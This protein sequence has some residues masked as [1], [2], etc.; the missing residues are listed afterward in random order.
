MGAVCGNREWGGE[1]QWGHLHPYLTVGPT[2]RP[3]CAG[4][5][6]WRCRAS[7]GHRLRPA[8][9]HR[10]FGV[11]SSSDGVG[12][13]VGS[14]TRGWAGAGLWAAAF[15][16]CCSWYK[17]REVGAIVIPILEMRTLRQGS[18]EEAVPLQFEA[19]VV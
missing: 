10:P 7:H 8:A 11:C 2:P 5:R 17:L 6:G 14:S 3:K 19:R 12:G 13:L 4:E 15:A 9:R 18:G 1:E 16:H